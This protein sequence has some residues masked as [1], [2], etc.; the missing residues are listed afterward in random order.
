MS[1]DTTVTVDAETYSYALPDWF[2][3]D[4]LPIEITA[5]SDKVYLDFP[6]FDRFESRIERRADVDAVSFEQALDGW[7]SETGDDRTFVPDRTRQFCAKIDSI[8]LAC[9]SIRDNW[10]GEQLFVGP[11]YRYLITENGEN[12]IVSDNGDVFTR[13]H[14]D[15]DEYHRTH[16]KLVEQV[17]ETIDGIRDDDYWVG[18]KDGRS[19]GADQRVQW[20]NIAQ[21]AIE[22]QFEPTEELMQEIGVWMA[23]TGQTVCNRSRAWFPIPD[24]TTPTGSYVATISDVHDGTCPSCG[25]DKDEHWECIESPAS[26]RRPNLYQCNECGT[27]KRGITTG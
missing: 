6:A 14:G 26:I 27:K 2:E 10:R 7:L 9:V 25:A 22:Q 17:E 19:R 15:T 11:H 24:W 4:S 1:L 5:F 16:R 13:R 18:Y 21:R 23:E 12:S 20:S 8:L 3:G